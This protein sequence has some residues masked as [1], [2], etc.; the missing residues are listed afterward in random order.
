M[1]LEFRNT[2]HLNSIEVSNSFWAP[3]TE[4]NF[5]RCEWE[6]TKVLNKNPNI[7]VLQIPNRNPEFADVIEF[8]IL[9]N[10]DKIF[11]FERDS[12]N[13]FIC[14]SLKSFAVLSKKDRFNEL[15]ISGKNLSE[16]F[17]FRQIKR[18]F[19][20]FADNSATKVAE[21]LKIDRFLATKFLAGELSSQDCDDLS[22][23]LFCALGEELSD[24][25]ARA[26][27]FHF[28]V[29]REATK[30]LCDFPENEIRR[31]ILNLKDEIFTLYAKRETS[32]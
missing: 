4:N 3:F 20:T 15:T 19:I 18:I 5:G 23:A 24:F 7:V 29:S 22:E 13:D 10:D 2:T 30:L 17:D 21:F 27:S 9:R 32:C 16:V 1:K 26:D 8:E 6:L 25:C 28:D 12:Q 14:E 11:H 31:E